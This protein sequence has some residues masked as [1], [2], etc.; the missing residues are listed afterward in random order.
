M[1]SQ[2]TCL[3]CKKTLQAEQFLDACQTWNPSLDCVVFR[4]LHCHANSEARLEN[5][6]VWH[7]Y[8]YAAGSAHFSPQLPEPLPALVVERGQDGLKLTLDGKSRLI[9]SS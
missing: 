5:G 8:I 6:T 1:P 3:G 9:P 7:G 4:C 2:V